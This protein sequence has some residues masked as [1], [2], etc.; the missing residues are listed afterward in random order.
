MERI[1]FDKGPEKFIERVIARFVQENAA[2]RRKVDRGKYWETPLVGFASGEDPL[3]GRYK[4]IVGEFHFT[5]QEIFELTFGG[6]KP[7]K[8]LS[9][10]SWVLPTSEDIRKSNRKET[11]Y[12]SLL[13]AHARDFGEQFNVKLR[14]HL[15][16]LL[17]KRGHKAVAPMNS[18]FW[19]RLRSPEVGIASNWSERHIAYA[20][21][22]GAFGLSD[23]LIT[24][25]GKAMRLGSVVVDLRLKPSEKIYPHH[26]ANCLYY[27]NKTCKTCASRCPAGAITEKG[28]DKDKCF[29]Y[30]Y[31]VVG[32]TKKT[33]Y[34]VTIA[35]CGL[36][37]T[38]VPCEFE[39]PK[40][41]QKERGYKKVS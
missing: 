17:K 36:C 13:W 34:G 25:K 20:C 21:G 16:S 5:P 27:F 30:T 14:D 41:I 26:K 8:D 39:I 29:E 15:V 4:K 24:A 7:S 12:P 6:R 28:H 38:K 32:E 22:L 31:S 9:V 11:R 18:P 2:N 40:L 3:F 1:L 23:G 10:I 33:E 37:Q 35:G 19:K